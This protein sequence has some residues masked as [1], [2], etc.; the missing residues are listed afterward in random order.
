MDTNLYWFLRGTYKERK[1]RLEQASP[2]FLRAAV[3]DSEYNDFLSSR[4]DFKDGDT[5]PHGSG[6]RIPYIGWFWRH[7]EFHDLTGIPIGDCGE[8]IG[9]MANNK[10]D[11]SERCLTLEE[12]E[13]VMEII[14]EAMR[15]SQQGGNLDEIVKNTDDKLD[16]LWGYMQTLKV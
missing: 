7:I 6:K 13:K 4:A 5:D 12:G 3:L 16:E 2:E 15:L 10:W 14:D 11:Y 1:E 8:F 9:F